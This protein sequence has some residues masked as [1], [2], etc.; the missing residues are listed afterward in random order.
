MKTLFIVYFV[1]INIV[2]VVV[3]VSDKYVASHTSHDKYAPRVPERTLLMLSVLGGSI[4]MFVTMKTIRH[5]TK[6][7]KFMVGIPLIIIIQ[8]AAVFL[9]CKYA[10]GI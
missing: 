5:K 7:P 2:S 10:I 6:K 9:V 3:T 8:A 4:S 1:A